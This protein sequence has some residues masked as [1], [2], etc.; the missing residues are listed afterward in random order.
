MEITKEEI[1]KIKTELQE[2]FNCYL[3]TDLAGD[4]KDRRSK[5]FALSETFRILDLI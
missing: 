3:I 4:N 2:T 1:A 5:L